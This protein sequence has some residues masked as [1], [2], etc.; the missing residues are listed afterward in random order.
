MDKHT[1]RITA[2]RLTAAGLPSLAA[3]S[4]CFRDHSTAAR[5]KESDMLPYLK[6]LLH[7]EWNS[8]HLLGSE[9]ERLKTPLC[10]VIQNNK[11]KQ[12]LRCTDI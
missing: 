8:A 12:K 7:I 9:F 2:G 4:Q 6:M 3:S 1:L 10:S 11:T 5:L